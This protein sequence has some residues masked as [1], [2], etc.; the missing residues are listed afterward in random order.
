MPT[1][2]DEKLKEL[3]VEIFLMED[4]DYEDENGPDQIEGWDSLS[5]ISLAVAIHETFDHHMTPAQVAAVRC[6]GD[7]RNYLRDQGVE[8]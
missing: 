1:P 8:I 3:M 4:E 5:M 6:I 7:V 2:A